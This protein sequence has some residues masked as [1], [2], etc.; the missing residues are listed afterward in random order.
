M[1][2]IRQPCGP[3]HAGLDW[4]SPESSLSHFDAR[5]SQCRSRAPPPDCQTCLV[6]FSSLTPGM[7]ITGLLVSTLGMGMF[8]YGKKSSRLPQL[9]TGL[10]LMIL[11][12]AVPGAAAMLSV[13]GVMVAAMWFGVRAGL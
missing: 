3:G 12:M 5:K 8:M 1:R 10:G 2:A 7:L 13:S 9:A 4:A 6:D 11:P